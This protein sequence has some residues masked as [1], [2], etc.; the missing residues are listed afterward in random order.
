MDKRIL[1]SLKK[2]VEVVAGHSLEI[3][4]G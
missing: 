3:S 4:L 2:P 1:I